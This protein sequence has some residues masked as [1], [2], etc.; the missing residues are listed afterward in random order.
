MLPPKTRHRPRSWR[1]DTC[2]LELG[3][4]VT[5]IASGRVLHP[6]GNLIVVHK[7]RTAPRTWSLICRDNHVTS[8]KGDAMSWRDEVI[9]P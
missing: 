2:D 5:S 9:P 3:T 6:T 1:C 7:E 8:W 4:V